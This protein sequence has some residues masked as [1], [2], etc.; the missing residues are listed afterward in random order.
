MA[1]VSQIAKEW[2]GARIHKGRETDQEEPD[3]G[4]AL[5]WELPRK[6][7]EKAWLVIQEI[8]EMIEA[9]RSNPVFQELAAGPLEDLLD[10]HG[11]EFIDR[12]ETLVQAN[13]KFRLLLGG[14]WRSGI[15]QAVW[16]R[17]QAA[18]TPDA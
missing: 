7:P 14:V 10:E 2:V 9:T 1:T 13:P 17:I 15:D 5:D 4:Q 12:V 11:F 18:L 16:D 6:D 3:D 8:L